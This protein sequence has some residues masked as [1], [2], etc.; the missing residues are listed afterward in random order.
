MKHSPFVLAAL[1]C[2]WIALGSCGYRFVRS[3]KPFGVHYIAVVPFAEPE[4]V[5]I[6]PDLTHE[7]ARLLAAGG[8]V[9]IPNRSG[10]QAILSGEVLGFS[11][12]QSPIKSPG[13]NIP[14]YRVSISLKAHLVN[15]HGKTLWTTRVSA[16]EDYLAQGGRTPETVLVTEANRRRAIKRLAE[17]TARRI[18]E[19]LILAGAAPQPKRKS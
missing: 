19:E 3:D 8:M 6:A 5:G 10:A 9:V 18:H 1:L 7:L 15:V 14:A 17:T 4:P 13:E 12:S 2:L 16:G 11:A